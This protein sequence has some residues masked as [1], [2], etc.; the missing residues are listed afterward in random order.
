MLAVLHFAVCKPATRKTAMKTKNAPTVR[1]DPGL[2]ELKRTEN[3]LRITSEMVG[4]SVV[5]GHNRTDKQ[6]RKQ[7]RWIEHDVFDDGDAFE[8]DYVDG[9]ERGHWVLRFADGGVDEGSFVN[10]EKHGHWGLRFTDGGVE[11]GP[12]MDGK[13][14]GGWVLR[15]GDGTVEEG[16]FVAGKRHGQWVERYADGTVAEGPYVD[17]NKHGGFGGIPPAKWLKFAIKMAMK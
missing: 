12:Y 4:T 6:G 9:K 15:W 8:G 3:I 11:E 16:P 7:G 13:A 17:G 1:T 5:F 10:G 2:S 14:H